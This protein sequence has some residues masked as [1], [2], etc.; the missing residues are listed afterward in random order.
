MSERES[1]RPAG[2]TARTPSSAAAAGGAPRQSVP[3]SAADARGAIGE[4]PILGSAAA[5]AAG[6]GFGTLGVFSRLFY[7]EGG[8]E[9]TLLVLRY[10]VPALLL[11]GIALVRWRP[12]PAHTDLALSMLLGLATLA[13]TFCLLAG[14]AAASPGL[15]TLLF[16]IYPLI[17]TVAA[18]WLFAEEL[19]RLRLV[20]LALGMAGI[21][22]T[23]GTPSVATAAG[24]GWGLAAGVCVSVFILGGRHVM[25]RSVDSFQFVTLSFVGG[26]ITL[27]PIAAAVGVDSPPSAAVGYAACL[28]ALSTLL[29]TLLFYFG[30]RRIGAG[31]A[32]RL[33]TIEPV[34]AVVLSYVVLGDAIAASQIAGGVLV[35]SAV[36][37]LATPS[38][39]LRRWR[40]RRVE[41][42]GR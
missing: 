19:T 41:R 25:A 42:A 21:A 32:S 38:E 40:R 14:F 26:A 35:V 1:A 22:L 10:F 15:V 9:F 17:T 37:L 5:I 36:A 33:A 6:V 12:L 2:G 3:E 30:V 23:V 7:D 27:L 28:V 20:L 11:V 39:K 31:G 34:T 4:A 8:E 16:Y 29:P 13:A 18:S 24:I